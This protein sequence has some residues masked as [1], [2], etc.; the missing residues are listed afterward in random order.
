MKQGNGSCCASTLHKKTD[1]DTLL[2]E[3]DS[4]GKWDEI[5]QKSY[6]QPILI[7]FSADWCGPCKDIHSF[8]LTLAGIMQ[9]VEIDVDEDCCQKIVEEFKVT[10]MPTFIGKFVFLSRPCF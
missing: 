4:E 3:I 9:L 2:I 1:G 6:N 7:K 10:M 5:V 8:F